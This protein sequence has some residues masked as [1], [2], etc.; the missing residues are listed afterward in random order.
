MP[1]YYINSSTSPVTADSPAAAV[2]QDLR[3]AGY[4]ARA[5]NHQHVTASR[6]AVEITQGVAEVRTRGRTPTQVSIGLARPNPSKSRSPKRTTKKS[7]RA[8]SKARRAKRTHRA[9]PVVPC[10]GRPPVYNRYRGV[11]VMHE[12]KWVKIDGCYVGGKTPAGGARY[13]GIDEATGRPVTIT[14]KAVRQKAWR[15]GKLVKGARVRKRK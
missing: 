6:A 4:K 10:K 7:V 5:Y 8:P 15:S 12:G 14:K 2:A 9:N 1:V 11:R 3:R 13:H